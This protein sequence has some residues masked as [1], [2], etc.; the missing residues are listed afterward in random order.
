MNRWSRRRRASPGRKAAENPAWISTYAD[1]M[2]LLVV[3]FVCIY[4][5]GTSRKRTEAFDSPQAAGRDG[6][7]W[8][9]LGQE[10]PGVELL[11]PIM[12]RRLVGDQAR[13]ALVGYARDPLRAFELAC[14]TR[15]RLGEGGVESS[16]ILIVAGGRPLPGTEERI[17]VYSTC[18]VNTAFLDRASWPIQ[19]H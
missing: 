6:A 17:E 13:I 16:R 11:D 4:S 15:D 14:S 9:R 3:L 5:H 1:L 12:E 8:T 18:A 2:S 10:R 7:A 19:Q